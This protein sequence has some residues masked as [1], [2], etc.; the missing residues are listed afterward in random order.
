MRPFSLTADPRFY[1]RSRSHGRVF[2]TLLTAMAHRESLVMVSG[3]L[4]VG[5]TTLCRTLLEAKERTAR[6]SLV[7]NALLSP[8]DLL[9]RMLQDFGA[10][11]AEELRDA[12]VSSAR[13][14]ALVQRVDRMLRS[15]HDAGEAAVLIVDEAQSLPPATMEQI[16]EVARLGANRQKVLQTLLVGEPA[17]GAI[18]PLPASADERLSVRARLLPLERDECESY[19]QHRLTIAGC[20]APTFSSRAIA[21]IHALSGGLPRLVNLLCERAMREAAAANSV[22]VE[23]V[24]IESAASALDLLRLKPRRLRWYATS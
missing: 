18:P 11:S 9:R 21:A 10:I 2:D 3:D 7:A 13:R 22:R 24:L 14:P 12:A 23:P 4:G 6:P 1:Y 20:A 5:K 19:V 15:M 17:V 8:E 16:I